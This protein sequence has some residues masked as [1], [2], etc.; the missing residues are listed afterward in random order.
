VDAIYLHIFAWYPPDTFNALAEV[1]ELAR[2]K[3][4]PIVAW[5]MGDSE[6]CGKLMLRLEEMGIPA[7]DEISKGVR[8]LSA[9]T[10]GR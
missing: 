6:A 5:T 8:V 2:E 1:A 3:G 9:L 4:K 10:R 7:V